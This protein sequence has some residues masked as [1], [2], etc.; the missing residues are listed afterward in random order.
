MI[1]DVPSPEEVLRLIDDT[2][3]EE[4]LTRETE[5]QV[6]RMR[7]QKAARR[8]VASEAFV[9]FDFA[10][11]FEDEM[12]I[13]PPEVKWTIEGLHV[14]GGNST[15]IAGFKAGKTT[16]MHSLIRS[17]VDGAPFLGEH[18]MR[19]IDGRVMY[20]NF[21]VPDNLAKAD[22]ARAGFMNRKKL[23][24]WP[25]R[26]LHLD[27]MDDIAAEWCV[28][29][30]QRLE[31]EVWILDPYSGA[32]NGNENDNSEASAFTK[33][34]D[35]IK[36]QS[37]VRDL[38]MP[39]HTGGAQVEFGSE[40]ARGATKLDDWADHRWILTRD[41]ETQVRYFRAEGRGGM[42]FDKERALA[43]DLVKNELRYSSTILGTRKTADEEKL[44]REILLFIE[45]NPGCTQNGIEN[46]VDGN[47]S[48]KR[49]A[50]KR[51]KADRKI[52]I[53]V[54]GKSHLHF[55]AGHAALPAPP[56]GLEDI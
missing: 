10:D 40:R 37:G 9:P 26:G 54:T 25:L 23:T 38:F 5:R 8:L 46:G 15:I 43:Y 18:A 34:V 52:G 14:E 35:E 28:K 1:D 53:V 56:I 12:A 31:I 48:K 4:A 36:Y 29:Q 32:Y 50:V 7:A 24:H 45:A 3:P 2:S 30:M 16:M 55:V 42:N 13:A 41:A 27:I 19:E 17:L 51:L 11:N 22:L 49:T 39:V 6:M 21:E 20:W 44:S 47:A 33:R